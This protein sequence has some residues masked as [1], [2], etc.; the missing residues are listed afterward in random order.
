MRI[1]KVVAVCAAVGV[2]V[3]GIA[4]AAPAYADPVSN[5]YTLV[6]SDT[7]QDAANA[8]ANGTTVTGSAVRVTAS[9]NTIGSFDA[10]GSNSIQTK[11]SGT[12]FARPAGSGDG[13][14]ALS[15]SIDGAPFSV[16]G[17]PTPAKAITAQVDI[18]RSS[19]GPGAAANTSGVLQ[20]FQFGR[21]A[22]SYAYSGTGIDQLTKAQ[23]TAIYNCSLT[24]V[25]GVDV[26]PVLPQS[27]S[28]TRKFFLSAIGITTPGA[29]VVQRGDAEN[30]GTVL[31]NT[32]ELIPFSVAS[33]VAQSNGAAQDRTGTARLG[34][35]EGTTVPFTG[36]DGSYVPNP[37]Y[38]ADT[39][40]GRDTYVVVEAARVNPSSPKYDP[41]LA[42]L[43]DPTKSKSLTNFGSGPSTSGAVK[44]K[45]GFL[46]PST[47]VSIRANAS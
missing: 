3:A 7:L 41:A 16:S 33:W 14:K 26:T 42:A 46:A 37:T 40:F 20:Y 43:V 34:S 36:A 29:C 24:S 31:V 5:S 6:G 2:A 18:A 30:D 15:R 23:L 39:T 12:Y 22:V 19:S 21:D 1:T 9:G 38:Y 27:A 10:F 4:F 44:T 32:G 11:N 45:F 35:A 8:L 28:G 47:T 13:V 17:N 25:N